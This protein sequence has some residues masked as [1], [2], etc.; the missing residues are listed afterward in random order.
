MRTTL[1]ILLCLF[2]VELDF[3]LPAHSVATFF[4]LLLDLGRDWQLLRL[5]G[6]VGTHSLSVEP[7]VKLLVY[8]KILLG[9]LLKLEHF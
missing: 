2:E 9:F 7:V 1:F 8:R 5:E 4:F 6:L 3:L